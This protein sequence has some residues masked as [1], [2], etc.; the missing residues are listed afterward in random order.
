WSD[1]YYFT[2]NMFHGPKGSGP[3]GARICAYEREKMLAGQKAREIAV[4]L[5]DAY[6]GFLPSDFD[7][8]PGTDHLPPTGSPCFFLSLGTAPNSLDIWKFKVNWANL[9]ASTFGDSNYQP[10]KTL[11]VSPFN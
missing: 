10:N 5:S 6:F 2:Y 1:A 7:G 11:D 4:Q 8:V 3:A 9:L